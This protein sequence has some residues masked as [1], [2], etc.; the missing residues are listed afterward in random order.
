MALHDI[1]LASVD[2]SIYLLHP[3]KHCSLHHLYAHSALEHEIISSVIS[4]AIIIM[5]KLPYS[6]QGFILYVVNFRQVVYTSMKKCKPLFSLF[7]KKHCNSSQLSEKQK[8]T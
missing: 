6:E 4:K 5:V 8:R 1:Y 2:I 7:K 3:C